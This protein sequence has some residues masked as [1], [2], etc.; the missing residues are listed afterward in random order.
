[1]KDRLA[2]LIT[3]TWKIFACVQGV[4]L[5]WWININHL[6][7]DLHFEHFPSATHIE[8]DEQLCVFRICCSTL[9]ISR[10]DIRRSQILSES[11]PSPSML[12]QLSVTGA[13]I[14]RVQWVQH[15]SQQTLAW[16]EHPQRKPSLATRDL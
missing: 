14:P 6:H 12:P 7:W 5:T 4:P 2:V 1:V 10:H 11:R 3:M 9:G 15:W 13:G 8:Q 16:K